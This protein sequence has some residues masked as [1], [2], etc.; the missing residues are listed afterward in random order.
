MADRA[1]PREIVRL[2]L[3]GAF[4]GW[5]ADIDTDLELGALEDLQSGTVAGVKAGLA[6]LVIDWNFVD[7]Q[8]QDIPA[9]TDGFR[10]VG[11]AL[12]AALMAAFKAA[13]ALPNS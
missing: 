4:D 11:T 8:G 6:R 1:Q 3:D 13:T 12:L 9:T 2:Q 5:W 7:K 10:M